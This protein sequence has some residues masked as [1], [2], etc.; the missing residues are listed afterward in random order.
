MDKQEISNA[1]EGYLAKNELSGCSLIVRQENEIVYQNRWGYANIENK[2]PI[3][4]DSIFRL[5]S[6]TKCVIAVAV[7]KL[8]EEGK[9]GIDDALSKYIPE[10]AR[11]QVVNDRRYIA[12][13]KK[14]KN[15]A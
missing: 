9:I 14:L 8:M 13:G 11:L 6:M 1:I 7:L 10:F 12:D 2:S 3:E 5:M 4:Y 15:M